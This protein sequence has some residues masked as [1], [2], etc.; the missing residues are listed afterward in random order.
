MFSKLITETENFSDK[1][2]DYF[3]RIILAA[4]RMQNLID[5][6]M[7]FSSGNTTE[8]FFNPCDLNMI[9]EESKTDLSLSILEKK[10]R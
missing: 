7:D 10:P 4:E 8:L 5:S 1:T 2:K 9:V 6:L 3:T